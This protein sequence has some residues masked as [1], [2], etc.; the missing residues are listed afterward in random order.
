MTYKISIF[1]LFVN[2]MNIPDNYLKYVVSLDDFN[3]G[4]EVSEIK[5]LHLLDF[6]Q[7]TVL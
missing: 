4:S 1:G 7:L 3:L 2:L 6:L 5:H